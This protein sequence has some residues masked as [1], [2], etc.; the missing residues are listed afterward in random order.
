MTD[1]KLT[2][3]EHIYLLKMQKDESERTISDVP[4]TAMQKFL[5]YKLVKAT[6]VANQCSYSLSDAGKQYIIDHPKLPKLTLTEK[7]AMYIYGVL[8]KDEYECFPANITI[9]EYRPDAVAKG[10]IAKLALVKVYIKKA[11]LYEWQLSKEARDAFEATG[12]GQ[13]YLQNKNYVEQI[14]QVDKEF[15]DSDAGKWST[16][17]DRMN[18]HVAWAAYVRGKGYEEHAQYIEGVMNDDLI[19]H[20]F[21][22]R[23]M[24]ELPDDIKYVLT[25]NAERNRVVR[26]IIGD[27]KI[28]RGDKTVTDAPTLD[29]NLYFSLYSHPYDRDSLKRTM[30]VNRKFARELPYAI[31]I[32]DALNAEL[33]PPRKE[34]VE[35]SDGK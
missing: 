23:F 26:V 12:V 18:M 22:Q 32:V 3:L 6:T 9:D 14:R 8:G 5:I 13:M 7:E 2:R 28:Q 19:K 15:F 29:W 10:L 11:G 1:V 27:I 31:D 35:E 30:E 16:F 17:E 21:K 4:N 34:E 25:L 24:S 33:H 20:E